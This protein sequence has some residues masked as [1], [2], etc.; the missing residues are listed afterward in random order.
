MRDASFARPLRVR[1]VV[2]LLLAVLPAIALAMHF[3]GHMVLGWDSEPPLRPDLYLKGSLSTWNWRAYLGQPN[4]FQ[5][6]QAPLALLYYVLALPFGVAGADKILLDAFF[7]LPAFTMY[8]CARRLFPRDPWLPFAAAWCYALSPLLFVRYY[9][10][11]MTVQLDYALL[12]LLANVWIDL[13]RRGADARRLLWL[14]VVEILFWPCANN[15]AYWLVPHLTAVALVALAVIRGRAGSWTVHSRSI[16]YGLLV[17]LLVNLFWMVPVVLFGLASGAAVEHEAITSA[18]TTGVRQDVAQG[19]GLSY[20]FRMSSRAQTS[21]GDLYGP[22]WTY[23]RSLENGLI[24]A[25]YYL[26]IAIVLLAVAFRWRDRR[27]VV[28]GLLLCFALFV[29]KGESPPLEFVLQTFYRIPLLGTIF[30]NGNDKLLPMASFAMAL[31][32]PIGVTAIGRRTAFPRLWQLGLLAVVLAMAFPYWTG[33]MFMA[34]PN[35]PTLSSM[36]PADAFAFGRSLDGLPSRLVFA[37]VSDNPQ[38]LSTAWGFY[39]P[40]V[41]GSMTDAGF[42]AN[43]ASTLNRPGADA[44]TTDLYRAMKDGDVASFVALSRDAG[45]GYAFVAHDVEPSYYGGEPASAVDAFLARVPQ[46]QIVSIVGP[47]TLWR[48]AWVPAVER[49]LVRRE[50]ASYSTT[51]EQALTLAGACGRQPLALV[52]LAKEAAC[53]IAP[54]DATPVDQPAPVVVHPAR[55]LLDGRGLTLARPGGGPVLRVGVPAGTAAVALAGQTVARGAPQALSLLPCAAYALRPYRRAG[56]VSSALPGYAFPAPDGAYV[57][58]PTPSRPGPALVT[59]DVAPTGA[60][61]SL[62]LSDPVTG[63]PLVANQRLGTSSTSAIFNAM[64]GRAYELALGTLGPL[65]PPRG[66]LRRIGV[67]PVEPARELAFVAPPEAGAPCPPASAAATFA[68]APPLA[69][70]TLALSG[71]RLLIALQ[72]APWQAP[73]SIPVPPGTQ[74]VRVGDDFAGTTGYDVGLPTGTAIPLTYYRYAG[75]RVRVPLQNLAGETDLT[76]QNPDYNAGTAAVRTV[77]GSEQWMRVSLPGGCAP[78]CVVDVRASSMTGTFGL[79]VVD[80][81]SNAVIASEKGVRKPEIAIG[82]H[83]RGDAPLDLYVYTAPQYGLPSAGPTS[84]VQI[85]E[86]SQVP[87]ASIGAGAI[88]FSRVAPALPTYDGAI[89][90]VRAPG[91]AAP[92]FDGARVEAAAVPTALVLD[93]QFD[94]FWTTLVLPGGLGVYFPQHVVADGYKNA[95]IV[96]AGISG[97]IVRFYLLDVLAAIGVTIAAITV[98]ALALRSLRTRRPEPSA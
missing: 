95:W 31:L 9:V 51:F 89:S 7:V 75:P 70:A 86:I 10:P 58:V 79:A 72:Q 34:R 98:L 62:W 4:V 88:S 76:V 54:V 78:H 36:P 15:L 13:A 97:R 67:A 55:A 59:V 40:N 19:S 5:I 57:T 14:A 26:W 84:A 46:T 73:L 71:G 32:L 24:A 50:I 66:F 20:T 39:G 35:G 63:D 11:I 92:Q 29:M 91:V 83:A 23:A 56:P 94:P 80:H 6:T 90:V 18:Y 81:A 30:R 96:P 64:P 17:T 41:Y 21:V 61:A 37:P 74:L 33:Q 44:L 3:H 8:Y 48:F 25:P 53:R 69:P 87:V 93:T 2:L 60:G 82:Y 27:V 85:A 28:L 52:P 43:P 47:Y 45:I 12:P 22:Y 42:V 65:L 68:L 16:W 38:L 1:P 77:N 49:R